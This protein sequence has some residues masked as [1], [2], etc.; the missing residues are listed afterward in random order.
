VTWRRR[1]CWCVRMVMWP[2][3]P[4]NP[5]PMTHQIAQNFVAC[6]RSGSGSQPL[7]RLEFVLVL[8]GH[9]LDGLILRL[10]KAFSHLAG[11][12]GGVQRRLCLTLEMRHHLGGEQFG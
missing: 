12:R 4:Q 3:Q 6:L 2:G 8:L 1:P 5:S 7:L 10:R 11:A 9:V